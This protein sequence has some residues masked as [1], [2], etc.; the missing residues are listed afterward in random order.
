ML[1]KDTVALEVDERCWDVCADRKQT[2]N[3]LALIGGQRKSEIWY[4]DG[5]LPHA[6]IRVGRVEETAVL[7]CELHTHTMENFRPRRDLTALFPLSEHHDFLRSR[8]AVLRQPKIGLAVYSAVLAPLVTTF[9]FFVEDFAN[10]PAAEMTDV[11]VSLLSDDP[12]RLRGTPAPA[13]LL[14]HSTR[15]AG[16]VPSLTDL[17]RKGASPTSTFH[18]IDYSSGKGLESVRREIL[19]KHG[20]VCADRESDATFFNSMQLGHLMQLSVRRFAGRSGRRDDGQDRAS[21]ILDLARRTPF[22]SDAWRSHLRNVWAL[23]PPTGERRQQQAMA[24]WIAA[25]LLLDAFPPD[26]PCGYMEP[27]TGVVVGATRC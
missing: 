1:S 27:W 13:V 7:D 14:V 22:A 3:C 10:R 6:A 21:H 24:A 5:R 26:A 18:G 17:V 16:I 20:A 4:G 23:V 12:R 11:I 19:E 15:H 25:A 9:C 2:L 8:S